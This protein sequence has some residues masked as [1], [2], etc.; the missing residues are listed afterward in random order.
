[1]FSNKRPKQMTAEEAEIYQRKAIVGLENLELY[2]EADDVADLPPEQYVEEKGIQIV[3]PRRRPRVMAA[4][5]ELEERI[6][7]LE[8][9]NEELQTQLDEIMDIIAPPE[10]E[11]DEG[12]DDLGEEE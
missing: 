3:N 7:E 1:M 12:G 11:E 5:Q 9:D 10:E 4:K 6:S 8:E 2:D